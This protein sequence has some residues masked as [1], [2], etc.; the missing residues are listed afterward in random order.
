MERFTRLFQA[1]A[2]TTLTMAVAFVAAPAAAQNCGACDNIMEGDKVTGHWAVASWMDSG[3]ADTPN[4]YH[5]G[6]EGGSCAAHHDACDAGQLQFAEAV[7][8]AVE[9]EDVT[10]LSELLTE[11]AA[12][13]VESRQAIQIPGCD[14]VL[15]VGHVPVSESLMA[16]LQVAMAD[17][18]D[19]Q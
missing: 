4:D 1:L 11:S 8:E 9:R 19:A 17:L 3:P 6:T 16:S 15:V 18:A 2:T 12:V 5:W 14:G 13:I 7:I 10:H